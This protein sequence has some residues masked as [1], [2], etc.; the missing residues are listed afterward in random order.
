MQGSVKAQNSS[1]L[2]DAV[3]DTT[4]AQKGEHKALIDAANQ[5]HAV[6]QYTFGS[7]YFEDR[8]IQQNEAQA[9]LWWQ[10]IHNR[11]MQ[12][13]KLSWGTCTTMDMV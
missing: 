1:V 3:N 9:L 11:N 12:R 4:M 7:V 2:I 5:G 13:R 8:E 6:A 10:K